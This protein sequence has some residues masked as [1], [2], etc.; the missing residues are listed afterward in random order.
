MPTKKKQVQAFL[1][2]ANYYCQFI[3]NYSAK[4][5][6]LTELTKDILFSSKVQQQEA[7][8]NLKIAFTSAPVLQPFDLSQDTIMETDASN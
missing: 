7:F 5:K 6:P 3:K 4:V 8:D 2:F 1:G